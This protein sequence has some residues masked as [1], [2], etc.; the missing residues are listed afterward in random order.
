METDGGGVNQ[1]ISSFRNGLSGFPGLIESL[2]VGMLPDC[3]GQLFTVGGAAVKDG[4]RSGSGQG[5]LHG[6]GLGSAAGAQEHHLFTLQGNVFHLQGLDKS[7]SVRIVADQ[8]AFPDHHRVYRPDN[9][10]G[11][12]DFIQ[13]GQHRNLMRHGQVDPLH[14]KSLQTFHGSIKIFRCNL[15]GQI[16]V[17]QPQGGE[18]GFLQNT[19][20]I[21]VYGI[22]EYA[23]QFGSVIFFHITSSFRPYYII[24]RAGQ[25][26]SKN[27]NPR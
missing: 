22:A 13:I 8:S 25:K 1:N 18:T 11:R 19:G 5:T 4:D 20:G 17:I 14:V 23:Y 3:L 16:T 24:N 7:F 9:P 26:R 2:G 15:H 6:D 21:S 10:G 12:G 27:K